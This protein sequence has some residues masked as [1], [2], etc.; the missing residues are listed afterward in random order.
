MFKNPR[1]SDEV[2]D[3]DHWKG[4]RPWGKGRW[5]HEQR[6]LAVAEA[7]QSCKAKTVLDLGCGDGPLLIRI[8]HEPAIRRIVGIDQC[9]DA[10]YGLRTK[11]S[12]QP[13][14]M[15]SKVQLIRACFTEPGAALEGFDAAVLVETIEHTHPD[16][17]SAVER[18]VFREF[19]PRTVIVTTPNR[20]FNALLGV[21]AGRFRHPGHQ[22]EWGR[23]KFG[24]WASRVARK[25]GYVVTLKDI[26][27][28]HPVYGGPTQMAIFERSFAT[29][30]D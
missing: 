28:T 20:D 8:M 7:I 30:T 1:K 16:R 25:S 19:S 21:P 10:L 17:L 13:F 9:A 11:L 27:G 14:I 4:K 22:F 24:S 12:S 23:A 18:A 6:I 3:P 5:L 29:S 15:R 26:P 2:S